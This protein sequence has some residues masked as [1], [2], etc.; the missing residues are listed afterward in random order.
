V[1]DPLD[2]LP[3][4]TPLQNRALQKWRAVLGPVFLALLGACTGNVDSV[5]GGRGV[6]VISIDALRAD[7]VGHN[8]YDRD[9]T[10]M[11]DALAAESV[12]F[13]NTWTAAPRSLPAH[14]AI[15]TGCDPTM[16]RRYYLSE[17]R[18]PEESRFVIPSMM[19]HIAV[20]YL[21]AGYRTAAFLDS[22]MLSPVTG[23]D[24]GFQRIA[25]M[26]AEAPGNGPAGSDVGG[27]GVS[28]R[29]LD[30]MHGLERDEDWFAYLQL[31]DLERVWNHRDAQ[32]DG[33]FRPRAGMDDVP[34]VSND[35]QAFFAQP[36]SRWLGGAVSLGTYEARYDGR[37]RG[38]DQDLG[39]M[40]E[41]LRASG[42]L[43]NTTVCIVG[44][45]GLQFGESELILDHGMY[46][47]EDL[48]VPLLIKPASHVNY[49][50]GR[51]AYALASTLDVA[52]TLLSLSGIDPPAGMLGRSQVANLNQDTVVREFAFASCGYQEGG[53][54]IALNTALELTIPGKSLG[55][56]GVNLERGW[57][58]AESESMEQRV[59]IFDPGTGA[60]LAVSAELH[61]EL[62]DAALRWFVGTQD[63][64]RAMFGAA[65]RGDQLP[66][67]RI[68]EL[69]Q[70]GYLG[71]RP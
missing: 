23:F 52:P 44:S 5:S 51:S 71:R 33:Y 29:F 61:D 45:F 63:A 54:A 2:R 9:T 67:G 56:K 4:A 1:K 30:W 14:C 47:P 28:K 69:V 57:Y 26:G 49:Q 35:E 65:W 59:R 40:L 37:L 48:H 12:R 15:L 25:P 42:R 55:A 19:P 6:L 60:D 62:L 34:P 66:P 31:S 20:E 50:A 7:H 53:A 13:T 43:T 3:T 70:L 24:A 16:A 58:G 17:S 68:D 39:A 41:V 22:D 32:W 36:R 10:P 18:A 38:L 64:R 27:V 8:G 21:R 46:T 11:L